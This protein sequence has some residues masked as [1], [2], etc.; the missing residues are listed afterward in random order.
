MRKEPEAPK[1][2]LGKKVAESINKKPEDKKDLFKAIFCDSD[3][4]DDDAE[5]PGNKPEPPAL[6]E[7]Q[8]STFIESF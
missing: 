5:L 7:T 2:E 4:D 8:K 3:D 6:S 1:T